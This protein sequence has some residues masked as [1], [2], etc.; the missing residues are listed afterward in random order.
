MLNVDERGQTAALLRLRNDGKS[1]RRFAGRLGAIYFHHAAA[2]KA[3]DAERAIDQDV[4]GRNNINVDN[5]FGA[6]AHNRSL[7]VILCD[8][9]N[10]EV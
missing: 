8:L 10:G 7:A 1:E 9:L 4:A 6:E 3:A 2:R 5:L